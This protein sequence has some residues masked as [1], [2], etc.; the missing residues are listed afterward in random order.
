LLSINKYIFVIYRTK[1]ERDKCSKAAFLVEKGEKKG[2]PFFLPFFDFKFPF[3][4]PFFP[5]FQNFNLATLIEGGEN[6]S[7]RFKMMNV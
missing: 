3:F 5:F 6:D 2:F 1:I 4:F 7:E